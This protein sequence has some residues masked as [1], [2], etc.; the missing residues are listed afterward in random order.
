MHDDVSV[1]KA[2]L[3]KAYNFVCTCQACENNWSFGQVII[4]NIIDF[5]F[6]SMLYILKN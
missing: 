2:Y 3:K 5:F 1:R 4:Y 6:Q